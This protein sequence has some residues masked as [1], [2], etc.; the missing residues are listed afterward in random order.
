MQAL[1][2]PCEK[3]KND[4]GTSNERSMRTFLKTVDITK[5]L[6]DTAITLW[7]YPA[8]RISICLR[9]REN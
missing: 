2:S 4:G 8:V 1:G 3:N 6:L 9:T 5:Y 7:Q